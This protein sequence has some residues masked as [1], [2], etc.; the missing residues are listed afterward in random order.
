MTKA[1]AIPSTVATQD[2]PQGHSADVLSS[3]YRCRQDAQV[4]G[5]GL[6]DDPSDDSTRRHAHDDP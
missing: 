3:D 1:G 4:P 6:P 5:E 2:R